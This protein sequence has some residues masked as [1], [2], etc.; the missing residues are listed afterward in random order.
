MK[1]IGP[2]SVKNAVVGKPVA[3]W[4]A[5]RDVATVCTSDLGSGQLE[6]TKTPA[7]VAGVRIAGIPYG[8]LLGLS[9][10]KRA[11]V[12][13]REPGY[14]K[15][16]KL[17]LGIGGDRVAFRPEPHLVNL[18]AHG[19]VFQTKSLVIEKGMPNGC[20]TNTAEL[21]VRDYPD[22]SI[23][24]GW[25]LSD[26]GCWRQHSWGWRPEESVWVETTEPRK[27]GFGI[28]LVGHEALKFTLSNAE[29]DRVIDQLEELVQVQPALL[30]WGPGAPS[31][32]ATQGAP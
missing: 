32:S 13:R 16:E 20:H 21:W 6:I 25:A 10:D 8:H 14:R 26:D 23:V 19:R 31:T 4:P 30:G 2:R 18:L 7:S 27:S 1:K 17:L 28:E 3:D 15:L 9:F 24:T 29:P 5:N 11:E 12:F 22:T